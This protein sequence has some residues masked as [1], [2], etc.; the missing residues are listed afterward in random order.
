MYAEDYQ[1]AAWGGFIL[2]ILLIVLVWSL[3]AVGRTRQRAR[4]AG[5]NRIHDYMLAVPRNDREKR[6]AVNMAFRGLALCLIGIVL[7][8]LL[9]LGLPPL[10]YGG[11]KI[12]LVLLGTD[13]LADDVAA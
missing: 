6:E 5:F 8:P 10:Y 12:T 13:L 7:T 11:R 2:L 4:Q 1:A 3:V 9:L